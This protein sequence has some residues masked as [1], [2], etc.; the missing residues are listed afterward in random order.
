MSDASGIQSVLGRTT[1]PVEFVDVDMEVFRCGICYGVANEPS[2][3][4]R[5]EGCS[6]LFCHGC[7][8]RAVR[9][10][11]PLC[12]YCRFPMP[13]RAPIKCLPLKN[14]LL[15]QQVF[16]VHK[17]ETDTGNGDKR[18]KVYTKALE[19]CDWKGQYDQLLSHRNDCR[20]EPLV[21]SNFPCT[22]VFQRLHLK[23]HESSCGFRREECELCKQQ[24][25]I[26]QLEEHIKN[27]CPAVTV[28]CRCGAEMLRDELRNHR[29]TV[30][31]T[32]SVSCIYAEFGCRKTCTRQE[33]DHHVLRMAPYHSKLFLLE[34]PNSS[35]DEPGAHSK[36]ILHLDSA[37]QPTGTH[38]AA[39]RIPGMAAKLEGASRLGSEWFYSADFA[40]GASK[41]YVEVCLTAPAQM[42]LFFF[43][44]PLDGAAEDGDVDIS[45]L[46]LSLFSGIKQ[47]IVPEGSR[48][49]N[50]LG[51]GWPL[52]CQD[53]QPYLR[54]DE[55]TIAVDLP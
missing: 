51:W 12:P 55:I 37:S 30:C 24:L 6:A 17:S 38:F 23:E 9:G 34:P 16:C 27:E 15:R 36:G 18:R 54:N 10:Q 41:V 19:T 1:L 5:P 43:A 33:M 29:A 22:E 20:C 32:S 47:C 11:Q 26:S 35:K 49:P 42:R 31:S 39:L 8:V 21:C 52:F 53:V 25:C 28:A 2:Q 14:L 44:W 13:L 50:G 4:G 46:R 48:I 40:M 45:G 3:C 7:M